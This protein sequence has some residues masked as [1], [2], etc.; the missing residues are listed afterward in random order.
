MNRILHHLRLDHLKPALY[1]AA[2]IG[3]GALA[4]LP[5]RAHAQLG[6]HV[7]IGSAPPPARVEVVPAPRPH[8]IWSPGY[9]GWAGRHHVWVPGHWERA[10][11]GHHYQ[12]SEWRHT[13]HGWQLV[14]GGWE[15]SAVPRR[16]YVPPRHV[17]AAPPR[18][19]DA[20]RHYESRQHDGRWRSPSHHGR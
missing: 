11:P 7:V 18:Q 20:H 19:H 12:R 6:V 15:R 13:R 4:L 17:H 16:V 1:A 9:W 3:I 2:A 14:R 10:R 8:H 5:G